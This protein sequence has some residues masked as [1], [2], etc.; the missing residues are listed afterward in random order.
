MINRGTDNAFSK[1]QLP[2]HIGATASFLC[3]LHCAALPFVIGALPLLGLG[4]LADHRVERVF[5]L[6]A[7]SL[8]LYSLGCGYLRHRHVHPLR[9]ALPGAVLLVFGVTLFEG[10]FFWHSGSLTCGG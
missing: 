9:I 4:F 1:R 6:F 5:V 7:V 10:Q 8:A 3:A 2:D